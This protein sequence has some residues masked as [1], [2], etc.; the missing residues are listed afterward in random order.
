MLSFARLQTQQEYSAEAEAQQK[1]VLEVYKTAVASQRRHTAK[2][3][4]DLAQTVSEQGKCEEAEALFKE[5][6]ASHK[7]TVEDCHWKTRIGRA[8]SRNYQD[9]Q[10]AY[11]PEDNKTLQRQETW[12]LRL[13][14]Q[15]RDEEGAEL[16]TEAIE[17]RG[18]LGGLEDLDTIA[19]M[20]ILYQR[21][22][23]PKYKDTICMQD[24]HNGWLRD[25]FEHDEEHARDPSETPCEEYVLARLARLRGCRNEGHWQHLSVQEDS[26][27][28]I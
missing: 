15:D 21:V 14:E 24:E 3:T 19:M 18:R 5:V 6:V 12:S 2:I 17:C 23:G 9:V 11:G 1:Q 4:R 28:P 7:A 27:L 26:S 22:L 13:I 25:L 20:N 16:L 10:G 8:R